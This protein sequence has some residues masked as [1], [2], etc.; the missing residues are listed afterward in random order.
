MIGIAGT[1]SAVVLLLALKQ[2]GTTVAES[3]A[4]AGGAAPPGSSAAAGGVQAAGGQTVLG[5]EADT[6][7]GPVQVQLTMDGGRIT[8]AAAVKT[9]NGDENS[10]KLAARAVPELNK[11]AVAA[12][13]A[14]IDT[15]SGATYTSE[16][17][18]KSLQ[19]ALDKAKGAGAQAPGAEAGAGAGAG[20]D[21]GAATGGGAGAEPEA[22]AAPEAPAPEAPAAPAAPKTVV[23]DVAS[24]QYGDVQV[25]IT[26][27]GGKVTAADAVK[28][29][30]S[31]ENSRK[32]A[33][34]AVPQ[35]NKAAVA[36]QSAQVDAVSG[37][38]FTSEGYTK[39]LQSALDKAGL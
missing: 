30:N 35:L 6:Q 18:V 4:Q 26:V 7:F 28:A 16:G 31:D 19:S 39:S 22:P 21:P 37:A 8:A 17:Y 1:T 14:Q 24:T 15:V 2:P 11:A 3:S 13:S 36:A 34:R 5:D 27:S 10:R 23:G 38:T 20:T 29:P 25:Q 33:A 9:P 32:I 12:Q